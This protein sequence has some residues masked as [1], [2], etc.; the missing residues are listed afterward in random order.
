[1]AQGTV[2]VQ[3]ARVGAQVRSLGEWSGERGIWEAL[4]GFILGT[5]QIIN[6]EL[7]RQVWKEDLRKQREVPRC[8]LLHVVTAKSGS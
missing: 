1:M 6:T 5:R 2:A 3:G 7:K 8:R 4:R